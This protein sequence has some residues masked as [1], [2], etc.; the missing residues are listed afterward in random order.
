M[1]AGFKAFVSLSYMSA[2][3]RVP[4]EQQRQVLAHASEVSRPE[5][6]WNVVAQ[7]EVLPTQSSEA[8]QQG[9]VGARHSGVLGQCHSWEVFQI[10]RPLA[11]GHTCRH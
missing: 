3:Q 2:C 8:E 9:R 11:E 4:Y 7:A 1:T 10:H 5:P 6:H